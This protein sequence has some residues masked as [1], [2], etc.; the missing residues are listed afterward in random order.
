[1][2]DKACFQ[3]CGKALSSSSDALLQA[4]ALSQ[5]PSVLERGKNRWKPNLANLV[6]QE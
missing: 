3:L 6:V 5:I 1:M 2:Y 4:S